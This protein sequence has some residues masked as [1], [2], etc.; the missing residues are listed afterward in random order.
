MKHF[1]IKFNHGVEIGARLAYVGHYKRTG[2]EKILEIAQDELRHQTILALI[3]KR[4]GEKPSKTIDSIFYIVGSTIGFLCKVFPKPLLNL[5]ASSM[6]VFAIFNY[7]RLASKYME[8]NNMF[9]D[10]AL[11]ELKHKKYFKGA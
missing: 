9:V 3:L 2:D 5:V 7:T 11:K 1:Q 6:E 4:L 8:F 10:M